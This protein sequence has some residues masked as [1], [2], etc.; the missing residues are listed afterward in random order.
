MVKFASQMDAEVLEQLRAYAKENQRHLS[1]V[2]NEAVVEYLE[3]A[4]IRPAFRRGVDA[5]LDEHDEVLRR[6]AK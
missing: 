6:L 5:V 2:L 1:A 4:H 3:R